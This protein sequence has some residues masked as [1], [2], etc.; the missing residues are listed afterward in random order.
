MPIISQ[1]P[2]TES[3]PGDASAIRPNAPRAATGVAANRRDLAQAQ[4]PQRRHAKPDGSRAM[5]PSVSLPSSPYVGGIR[6]LAGADRVH[7]DEDDAIK[8]RMT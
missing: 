4:R 2:V 7:D 6:Q 8:W 5:L 3:L 1:W